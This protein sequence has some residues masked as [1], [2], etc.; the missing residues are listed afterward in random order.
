MRKILIGFVLPAVAA[1][2]FMAGPAEARPSEDSKGRG[3]CVSSSPKPSGKGGR[4]DVA[5]NDCAPTTP[6]PPAPLVCTENGNVEVNP[7][8]DTVVISAAP[9][10]G[11]SLECDT[12]VAV[13]AGDTLT[14][15]YDLTGATC[16]GGVP[17]LFL[18]IDGT[19]Y[20]TFD[21]AEGPLPGACGT[22][23]AIGEATQGT[24]TYTIP[25]TGTVDQ[26]G[27]VYDFASGS[28]E[29][30]NVTLDGQALNF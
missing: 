8:T 15:T 18:L 22:G 1:G 5:R 12:N 25:V 9:P 28:V 21:N 16:G 27:L 17:R 7:E 10:A 11:S 19:Y 24:V 3:R 4:S 2:F 20:N 6:P 14:F 30:S 29:Y 13:T 26:I 23:G